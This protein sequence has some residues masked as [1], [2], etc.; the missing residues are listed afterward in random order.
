MSF[1]AGR[2]TAVWNSLA[3][4]QTADGFRLSHSFF[5]R[6]ITG[7]AYAEAPQD[8]IYRGAEMTGQCRLI[9]YNAAAVQTLMWP[10]S[11]TLYDMGTIGKLAVNSG[12]GGLAKALVLTAV[13][14]TPS[15]ATPASL[16]LTYAKLREGFPV[17]LLY[18]PD[19]REVPIGL[20]FLPNNGVFATQT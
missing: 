16:T 8:S 9:E 4:G 18:A 14:G 5:E 7:D 10:V 6:L 19:L 11:A 12:S 1:I 13:S 3:L 17:E 2:Y 15:A 20:R